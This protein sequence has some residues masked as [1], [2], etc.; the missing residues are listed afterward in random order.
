MKKMLVLVAIAFAFLGCADETE[1]APITTSANAG[2]GT[3][4]QDS[5]MD[6]CPAGPEGPRG[7]QGPQGP[8]GAA[9]AQGPQG[10]MGSQ[11]PEGPQGP[12]GPQGETGATGATGAP[13]PMGMQGLP[14]PAGADGG[15]D[16]SSIYTNTW[17]T[18]AGAGT[19]THILECNA[20]DIAISGGCSLQLTATNARI[21]ANHGAIQTPGAPPDGHVCSFS[22]ASNATVNAYV[23]CINVP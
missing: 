2:G 9:G 18:F 21:M 11:G 22:L 4:P 19:T 20:G 17:S 1:T 5:C 7:E 14:G 16:V 12:A 23:T 6:V 8:A 15:F 10:P 13:G 3:S